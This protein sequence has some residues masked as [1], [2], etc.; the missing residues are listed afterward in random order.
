VQCWDKLNTDADGYGTCD[1]MKNT[2]CPEQYVSRDEQYSPG[3]ICLE[4]PGW[5][6]GANHHNDAPRNFGVE[7]TASRAF[8]APLT[9]QTKIN[10]SSL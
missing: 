8:H 10:L 5:G 3:L 9:V 7:E 6:A 1:A 4:T 2:S